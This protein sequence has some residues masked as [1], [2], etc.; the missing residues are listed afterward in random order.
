MKRQKQAQRT[1][2]V[3]RRSDRRGSTL[4][5]VLAL[6]SLLAFTGMVFYTFANQERSAADYFSE[7]AKAENNAD[8]DPFPWAL[9]QILTG[10]TQ[11]QKSSIIHDPRRRHSML[12]GVV[13]YDS[14]PYSGPGVNIIYDTGTGLPVVDNNYD[15]ANDMPAS[16]LAS[17]LNL[18][19]SLAAWSGA[20]FGATERAVNGIRSL[21]PEPDVDYTYPDHNN[22]W[23]AYRGYAIRDNGAAAPPGTRYERIPIFIPSFMRPALLKSSTTNGVGGNNTLTDV[24]WFDHSAHPIYS[25]RS[26]RPSA[27]H[28]AGLDASGNPVRRFLDNNNPA[29]AALVGTFGAFPLRPNEDVNPASFG[30]MGILT[31]HN[32]N[33]NPAVVGFPNH[34]PDTY[35]LDQDNDRDGI[36]EGI[37][38]DLG[39]PVQATPSGDLYSTIFSFTIYDLD[40]LID[41]NAHG[42]I[43]NL[44]RPES[45]LAQVGAGASGST[46][47]PVT[48]ISASHQGLG[49]HE[50][51]PLYGIA[52][53][54]A[55]DSDPAFSDTLRGYGADPSNRLEQANMEWLWM[56]TG[57]IDTTDNVWD[58]RWGDAS[59]L[60]YHIHNPNPASPDRLVNTLPRPGRAGNMV[61]AS[62]SP[63]N[64]G[65]NVGFDDNQSA[66]YGVASARTGVRRGFPHLLDVGGTGS[67][68]IPSDPRIPIMLRTNLMAPEQ[69]LQYSSYSLVGSPLAG[70]LNERKYLAGVDQ[71]LTTG[72]DNL[73]VSPRFNLEFEDPQEF[74]NDEE[75]ALAGEDVRFNDADLVPGHLTALDISAGLSTRLSNLGVRAFANGSPVAER[76]TTI[77]N[78][79]RSIMH[80]H[81]LGANRTNEGGGGDDGPRWWAW[82]AD[83][84]GPDTNDDGFPDGDGNPEFP[85]AFGTTP[86]NG[87]PFSAS[88]PFRPQVRRMLKSEVG[89]TQELILQLPLSINH[90][91]DVN[92]SADTPAEGTAEFLR[93]MQ[94]TG[95]R[96]RRLTEH[97]LA[98]ETDSAGDEFARTA[99]IP[100]VG[101]PAGQ[102]ALQTF[103]P[104]TFQHR[105][106]WA[107][108]DRQKLARD[109][110]VLLYTIGGAQLNAAGDVENATADN[111]AFA[112]YSDAELRRMAQ[113]AVNMVDAMDA[114]DVMTTFEYDKDLSDGWNLDDDPYTSGENVVTSGAG[115]DS[116]MNPLD[117]TTRGV[118]FGVEAQQLSLSEALAVRLEDFA[119]YE[120]TSND[121]VTMF[122]DVSAP[123]PLANPDTDR[124][125]RY[126]LHLEL[127]NN[128][129]YPIPLSVNG[130][131]GTANGSQAIWQIARVDR[132]TQHSGGSP[133]L[134]SDAPQLNTLDPIGLPTAEDGTT[135]SF[136]DGNSDIDG[137]NRFSVA[138]ASTANTSPMDPLRTD[139]LGTG[140]A[141]LYLQ[142]PGAMNFSLIS[143]DEPGVTTAGGSA[144]A[145]RASLDTIHSSHDTRYVYDGA[146]TDK[147][148][149]LRDIPYTSGGKQYFGNDK[150]DFDP[151]D[152]D[153]EGTAATGQGFEVVLRRRLNPNLPLVPLTENP[154]VEVDRIR[155]EF[156]D[157]FNF[158]GSAPAYSASAEFTQVTSEERE[159]PLDAANTF[160]T[161]HPVA[162]AAAMPP[163]PMDYRYNTI[164]YATDQTQGVNDATT[165][166][167]RIAGDAFYLWQPHFDRDFTSVVELFQLPIVG[168]RQLTQRLN[169]MRYAPAQQCSAA[170][171]TVDPTGDP[172]LAGSA[173]AMFLQPDALPAGTPGPND[174]AWYRLLQYV[175]VPSGVNTMLGNYLSRQRLPG[176]V[177]LNGIRHI[178]VYAGLIDD[179]LIADVPL[180]AAPPAAGNDPNNR[181]APFT[182]SSASPIPMNDAAASR[183][184]ADT[185]ATAAIDATATAV[186]L[187]GYKDRWFE[188]VAERDGATGMFDP[189]LGGMT[190][191]WIPGTPNAKPFRSPGYRTNAVN[192]DTGSDTH[193]DDTILRR[194]TLDA[195]DP[196]PATNRHW[197]E[198]GA[199][200]HHNDPTT[201]AATVSQRE[202]H[203][204]LSKVY[205]NSTTVSN[206]FIVY[207]TAAY[208]RSVEDP[209]GL[210]RVGS[211]MGLD[212]DGDGN[213]TN[214]AG[215]EKRAVFV[216]DRTELLNAYDEGTGTFDW[217]RLIKYRAD[218]ASDSQ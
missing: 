192:P 62:S 104:R 109:I 40:S 47:F 3:V 46:P 7:A 55:P 38:I 166:P 206:T 105:E 50:V 54:G 218:L 204:I 66:L 171:G 133:N 84:D 153:A 186:S 154:W 191:F 88:D 175:E 200:G 96:F 32:P 52:P 151:A 167:G 17:G 119:K 127:Q 217:Q 61:T 189:V 34:D 74:L 117:N 83:T 53:P 26:F 20:P 147:G 196:S 152:P 112:I 135:M 203:Q 57:R 157:L 137:G 9:Q 78:A 159:E 45:V 146:N 130:I 125:D 210:I 14:V 122:D 70:T 33:P 148:H 8:D 207:G 120:G 94:T 75:F 129:P 1:R 149:F 71:D 216:V 138:M 76:F 202:R 4:L 121:P 97:P 23:L 211:R 107:R 98:T 134:P 41:L 63:I 160:D 15:G 43:T 177:N 36:F 86:A 65:G 25:V 21:F 22:V 85:P 82:T 170:V 182:R 162:T 164:S 181:Y 59:A 101:T 19:S 30:R 118:V 102:A 2:P 180:A 214:D 108:R 31:G 114:D 184:L 188:F 161:R 111:S 145:P 213:Q 215:W 58:G 208:F 77:S 113:F 212:L 198:L 143:P 37:W 72:A 10:A 131:T 155:V 209:S 35:R 150:Y 6:L 12:S 124:R 172:G 99:T 42:N 199:A 185:G 103:P 156:K 183:P 13:G 193:L 142:L 173:V 91:L 110:Y 92:R 100:T 28:I 64:F 205:N 27:S 39:Y 115:T 123:A 24:D 168:P 132:T 195:N 73:I 144:G 158:T 11:N 169:R 95:L 29:D 80:R 141:D 187:P 90:I 106:F 116:G 56:V 79:L 128:Q 201:V 67:M 190:T 48:S 194:L 81:D 44:I 87:R 197:M 5:I 165:D 126:V 68:T 140:N 60:W 49:P 16:P 51:N 178:E 18:V 89:E 179:A 174:N 69:W 139:P 163:D 136:M 176:K 93:Y